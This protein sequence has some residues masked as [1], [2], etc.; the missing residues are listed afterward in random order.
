MKL[1]KKWLQEK[2]KG[3]KDFR[4]YRAKAALLVPEVLEK[5]KNKKMI[6]LKDKND[7]NG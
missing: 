7:A 6:N 2:S 1:G 5:L 4:D 3:R